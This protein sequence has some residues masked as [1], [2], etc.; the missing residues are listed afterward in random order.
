MLIIKRKILFYTTKKIYFSNYP[1]DI[2]DCDSVIFSFCKK[3]VDI[4]G[5]KRKKE[6]TTIIDLTQNLDEIWKKVNRNTRRGITKAKEANVNILRD[7]YYDQFYKMYKLFIQQMGLKSIFN[8]LGVGNYNLDIMKQYGTLFVAEHEG[9]I[10]AGNIV[11]VNNSNAEAWFSV[12][13]RLEVDKEKKNLISFCNRLLHWETIKYAKNKKI[14]SYNLSGLWPEEEAAKD[15]KKKGINRFKLGFG[16]EIVEGYSY[17]KCYSK[18]YSL[19]YY[20]YSLKHKKMS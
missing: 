12:S 13:K 16:G 9:E 8:I 11:L 3:K 1:F 7:C 4:E 5:F 15:P 18:S 6:I 20:L 2:E 17:Q 19:A 14:T 10:L